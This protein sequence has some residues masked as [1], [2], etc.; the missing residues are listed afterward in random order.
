MTLVAALVLMFG[1]IRPTWA[2][3]TPSVTGT[4]QQYLLNPHG[5]VEGLLLK[6][7]TVVRFPP[8]LGTALA[9]IVRPGDDVTVVGFFGPVTP[10]GGAVKAL[11]I[12]NAKTNQ[13]VVDQP[14]PT[15]PLPPEMRGLTLKPL[16][17]RGTVAHLLTN[18]AGDVDGL[19]L[20]G[21]EE[22]KFP[23]H[24]GAVVA[25]MLEQ[26][27]GKTVEVSGYGTQNAF[28]TV[29]DTISLTVDG[30]AI[31]LTGPGRLPR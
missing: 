18:E 25:L 23:P 10:H 3:T 28:G 20:S 17:L 5:E 2:Q 6:D 21:G 8:H 27:A 15:P 1:F 31:P 16:T 29:V 4:V 9:G 26:Q 7:G 14:P 30:Q 11:T 12:T 22:V 24:D 13:T 19:T